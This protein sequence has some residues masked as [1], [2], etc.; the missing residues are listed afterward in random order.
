MKKFQVTIEGI[1]PILFNRLIPGDLSDSGSKGKGGKNLTESD[2][3]AKAYQKVY[4]KDNDEKGV[5]GVPAENIKK[6]I[7]EGCGFAGVKIGRRGAYGYI[8]ATVHLD[9]DFVPFVGQP[10]EPDGIHLATGRIPPG[11]RGARVI[12]R[13]PYLKKGW[14]LSYCLYLMDERVSPP[15]VEDS[16]KEGGLLVG[17]CDHRPEFGRFKLIQFDEI[18][19]ES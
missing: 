4:R 10:V 2:L 19:D 6:N 8:R 11:P 13:R 5:L 7:L 1:V 16:I 14:Q 17:L 9:T 15:M 3:I 18:S 12:L